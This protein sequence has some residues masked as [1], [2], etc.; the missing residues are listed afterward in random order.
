MDL[1][2]TEEQQMLRDGLARF[3]NESYDFE[4]RRALSQSELGFSAAHWKTF[5][6]LGWLGL[7]FP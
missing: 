1:M 3:I 2:L 7:G 6:E 4:K 5:A